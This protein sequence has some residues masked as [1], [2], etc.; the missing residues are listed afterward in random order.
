MKKFWKVLFVSMF[1]FG[2]FLGPVS[3]VL[4]QT[5]P[6]SQ[7]ELASGETDYTTRLQNCIFGGEGGTFAG[8]LVQG[9][10]LILQLSGKFAEYSGKL[11]DIF[12]AYSLDSNAYGSEANGNF[13]EQGW[14]VI[15]DIANVAFIFTLLYIAIRH[16]LQMGSSDT[17]KLLTSLIVA[18]LLINFSLFFSKVIIDGG[19][20]LA[21]AFYNNIEVANDDY[22]GGVGVK[23]ISQALVAKVNPQV[24]LGSELFRPEQAPGLQAGTMTIGYSFFVIA[25]ATFV[26]V[27]I[28][29]VFLSTFLLFAARVIGLWFLMIF[30]PLAFV[31]LALPGGGSFLGQFGWSGWIKNI[32]KLSFMAPV[33]LFFLFLLVM[34]L[35]IVTSESIMAGSTDTTHKIMGVLIP[36]IAIVVILQRAK[37]IAGDMAGEFGEGLTKAVGKALGGA[38]AVTGA[39]AGLA[40]GTAAMAGRKFVG[41]AATRELASGV[42]Q[43]RVSEL[44]RLAKAAEARARAGDIGAAAQ[45]LDYRQRSMEAAKRVSTLKSRSESSFDV[46]RSEFL[47]KQ[48]LGSKLGKG[49]GGFVGDRYSDAFGGEKLKLDFGKAKDTS[50]K[51]QEDERKKKALDEAKLYDTGGQSEQNIALLGYAA[52]KGIAARDE[53]IE[54]LDRY[55]REIRSDTTLTAQESA[56]MME[57]IHKWG[58]RANSATTDE[59]MAQI[60]KGVNVR[61]IDENGNVVLDDKGEPVMD[62]RGTESESK[63]SATQARNAFAD[64][65]EAREQNTNIVNFYGMNP[66]PQTEPHYSSVVAD[67][68]RRGEKND[69]SKA[70]LKKAAEAAGLKFSDDHGDDDK[71]KG[72]H[73]GGKGGGGAHPP[74]PKPSAPAPSAPSGGGG[75]G[76][77]GGG[78]G[79][80]HHP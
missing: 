10:Y 49:I 73:G 54:H 29:I 74:A 48:V 2:V 40:L 6:P 22:T 60:I 79:G 41:G 38:L 14:G 3:A 16:I 57:T 20:I 19:N 32:M 59:E 51:K 58:E 5:E 78:G 44:N 45:A 61:K 34:F 62:L 23:T 80:A 30:S 47:Q 63:R 27:T 67:A 70:L 55:A 56:Q 37:S 9:A 25:L 36:F 43:K 71:G 65:V 13:V 52:R 11:L 68:I 69:D 26:N 28:G 42:N 4:A 64:V 75:G 53:V 1:V 17:K 76:H 24:I 72:G 31:S 66:T 39:G 35:S 50:I 21:R 18:A 77:G 7:A 33:F 15:R 12:I 46:R 8:C